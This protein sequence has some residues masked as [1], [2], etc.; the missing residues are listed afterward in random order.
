MRRPAAAIAVM[1][2][3]CVAQTATAA[4]RQPAPTPERVPPTLISRDAQAPTGAVV[5]L[6]SD[7]RETKN[8]MERLLEQYPPSLNRVLRLDPTLLTNADYLRPYPHLAAFL[9][10][11]PE[12]AHNPGFFLGNEGNF[13]REDPKDR[14]F[15]MWRD[16]MQGFFIATI[17]VVIA[18]ALA[19]LIKTVIEHRRWSRMSKVQTDVH[20]KLLDRFNS[21]EDLLAYMQTPAGRRFFESGPMPVETPRSLGA[22]LARILWSAQAGAVL[23]LAGIGVEIVAANAIEDVGQPLSAIGV[24]VLAVGI[25]FVVSAVTAYVLSKRLGLLGGGTAPVEPRV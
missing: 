7:A 10:Q 13:F 19:W 22:P 3:L 14:A 16:A 20:Y 17:F 21:N 6:S 24:V 2:A 4:Q 25:G 12:I 18:G 11:H 1:T 23:T 9:A 8:E 15:N 5:P